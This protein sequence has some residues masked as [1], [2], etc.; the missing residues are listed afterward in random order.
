MEQFQ[1]RFRLL[2]WVYGEG[3]PVIIPEGVLL[4]DA[5]AGQKLARVTLMNLAERQVAS[6]ELE[7]Q[8]VGPCGEDLGVVSCTVDG[9]NAACGAVFGG[10]CGIGDPSTEMLHAAVRVVQFADGSRWESAG[11]RWDPLPEPRAVEQLFS[12]Q[13]LAAEYREAVGEP[14]V[15]APR[16]YQGLFLCACGTV[17]LGADAPCRGC[18][19]TFP[20]LASAMNPEYLAA[21]REERLAREE[22]LRQ[23][24]EAREA[25][26]K[27]LR[28]E[29]AKQHR[30]EGGKFFLIALIVVVVLGVLAWVVPTVVIPQV[31]FGSAYSQAE[32]LLE[33]GQY[34]EAHQAFAALGDFSDAAQ[35]AQESLYQKAHT[36][37]MEEKYQDAI[38]QFEALGDYADSAQQAEDTREEWLEANYQAARELVDSG[39]YPAAAA[40]FEALG[41]YRDAPQWVV[42][43][44]MLQREDDYAMAN[45]AM[46]AGDYTGARELFLALG[47]YRE[48]SRLAEECRSLKQAEDYADGCAALEAKDY[49]T[50]IS[51][52]ESLGSY[53][54]VAG[55]LIE[56]HYGNG[57]ELLEEEK[58]A[59]AV[60]ELSLCGNYQ[61]TDWNLKN[62]KMG[63]AKTHPDREDEKTLA[64]LKELKAVYFQGAK[65]LYDEIF[66]W[67]VEITSF[68]NTEWGENQETV[69]KYGVIYIHF[70][71]T[72]GEPG[73]TTTIRTLL[74][75]PGGNRGTV[76]HNEVKDGYAG[77]SS[78]WFH[79]PDRAPTGTL[80]FQAYDEAGNLLCTGSVK[81][82]K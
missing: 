57:L 78:F 41:D 18:G 9:M 62:A 39:A 58:Y 72:G 70:K 55:K 77:Y 30:K 52:F 21:K 32:Q 1:E 10:D 65:T 24:K 81:V 17:N 53:E 36:L 16:M 27:E 2:P 63:Y 59:E 22:A 19:R 46:E 64:Y 75:V 45:A 25:D 15:Q 3:C 48:S 29:E 23:R 47:E 79:D 34:D 68:S 49:E 4:W 33:N 60:E 82:V 35:M 14:C 73:Q 76:Y 8:C 67:K 51:L 71:L 56:A 5:S 69:S 80:T 40:A 54:D 66:G 74:T 61:N 31:R 20:E 6:A 43:C 50:A 26:R 38:A 37:R 28:R 44:Q 13:S 11:G 7:L 42:E 12:E